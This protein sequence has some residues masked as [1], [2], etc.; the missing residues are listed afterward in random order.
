MSVEYPVALDSDYA[1]WDAFASRYWPAVYIADAQ[2]RIRHH[3]FGEG[4]YEECERIIQRFLRD[5]GRDRI[6]DDLVSVVGDGFEAQA[7]WANLESPETYLGYE[8]AQNFASPGGA[9]ASLA[10]TPRRIR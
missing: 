2:G 10:P 9:K 7:D 4:G 6:S 8:E 1:I 5:A 3:Q